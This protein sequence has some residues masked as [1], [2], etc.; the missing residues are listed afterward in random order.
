MEMKFLRKKKSESGLQIKGCILDFTT[1]NDNL[2]KLESGF[3][4]QGCHFLR[5]KN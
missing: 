4:N 5:I 2:K 1:S 3:K